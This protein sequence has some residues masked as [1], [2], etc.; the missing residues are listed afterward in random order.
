MELPALSPIVAAADT[1]ASVPRHGSLPFVEGHAR[2]PGDDRSSSTAGAVPP[3]ARPC[4]RLSI[5]RAGAVVIV[6]VHGQLE[7]TRAAGLDH[8][9]RDLIC[10]QGNR[11]IAIDA[12]GVSDAD[13]N[14]AAVLVDAGRLAE[15]HRATLVLMNP[16]DAIQ[17][18]L[19]KVG[20]FPRRRLQRPWR[21]LLEVTGETN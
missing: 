7:A 5:H 14:G 19:D 16:S 13:T 12:A 1:G 3:R 4:W 10:D 20:Q 2:Q 18:A 9:L 6:S 8:I 11:H 15:E 17:Q 21:A